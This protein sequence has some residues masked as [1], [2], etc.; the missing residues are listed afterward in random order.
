MGQDDDALLVPIYVGAISSKYVG[1]DRV[2]PVGGL[3]NQSLDVNSPVS[4]KLGT[5]TFSEAVNVYIYIMIYVY[6][7]YCVYIMIYYK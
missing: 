5:W 3:M 6:N 4:A 2:S 1:E 7:K